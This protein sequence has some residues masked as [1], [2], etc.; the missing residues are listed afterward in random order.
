LPGGLLATHGYTVR[1]GFFSG[2]CDGSNQL[3]FEQSKE[4]AAASLASVQK[5]L[6]EQP[7]LPNWKAGEDKTIRALRLRISEARS[8]I[9]FQTLRIANWKLGT[10]REVEAVET[11]KREGI[12]RKTVSRALSRALR[13]A[14][15]A[16]NKLTNSWSTA[17]LTATEQANISRDERNGKSQ[18]GDWF[19]KFYYASMTQKQIDAFRNADIFDERQSA[20][21]LALFPLCDKIEAAH[22]VVAAAKAAAGK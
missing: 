19:F 11:A 21:K 3:P 22:K 20:A 17:M 2:V 15:E 4:F 1:F 12:A 6:D 10:L 9:A 14:R 5:W 13:E 18:M 7:T 8:Y 16:L